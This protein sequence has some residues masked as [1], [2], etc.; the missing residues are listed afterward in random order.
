MW[1]RW[2]EA[3]N[4]R[5]KGNLGTGAS[6]DG[7]HISPAHRDTGELGRRGT[8]QVCWVLLSP[9]QAASMA[10]PVPCSLHAHMDGEVLSGSPLV[11]SCLVPFQNSHIEHQCWVKPC[12]SLLELWS[13]MEAPSLLQT[14]LLFLRA[15]GAQCYKEMK[16]CKQSI[17][18]S[19]QGFR[20]G[21]V[22]TSLARTV[23]Q[24]VQQWETPGKMKKK[25]TGVWGRQEGEQMVLG[26][27]QVSWI[28]K[29]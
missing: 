15:K 24:K 21:A 7:S 22:L 14:I 29:L 12:S 1:A 18:C 10:A 26:V 25:P 9:G 28:T 3:R 5:K 11:S 23:Q 20:F 27:T 19:P 6:D 13:L 4:W 16:V 8:K 2:A 17:L